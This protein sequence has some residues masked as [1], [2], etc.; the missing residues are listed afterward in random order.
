MSWA[1][2][3]V[4]EHLTYAAQD[5]AYTARVFQWLKRETAGD[6]RIAKLYEVHL[7][8]A[9]ICAE[10]HTRGVY[11]HRDNWE[12][13]RALC[14]QAVA[15]KRETLLSL[16]N[17]PEF[18]ATSQ[19]MQALMYERHKKPGRRCFG[20]PDP[21]DKRMYTDETQS[22]I[23]VDRKCL[24]LLQATTSDLPPDLLAIIAAW[25]KYQ[26]ELK[27]L[28][29]LNSALIQQAVG[30]DGRLRAGWNSC[31][32]DTM[33]FSCS[34]PN[35][36]QMEQLLRHLI[37]PAPDHVIV[38]AD[39][40]QLEI[41]VMEVVAADHVLGDAI[42]SGDIYSA[43]ACDY[44]GRD[45]ATFNPSGNK[46]DKASRQAA[47]IIRLARQYGAGKQTVFMQAL[48]QDPRFTFAAA[49][50]LTA[51]F[52]KRYY[53]TVKYWQEE[54]AR[55][56]QDGYSEGR[57]LHGRRTYARPPELSETVNY[58]IQRTAAEMMNQEIITLDRRL[59]AETKTAHIIIQLHDA[60]DVE[61]REHEEEKVCKIMTDV[62]HRDWTFCGMT[63]EFPIEM[64]VTRASEG[65][66]WA[67]V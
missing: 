15:E 16:V 47:K 12:F 6:E 45:P 4:E 51:K 35:L 39:K 30:P 22:S 33:R 63:R 56:K 28:G 41:R 2:S 55:V 44:F 65:G 46:A 43:E 48:M 64:K 31:G 10:M 27:R 3:K 11:F 62:M 29:Y 38:H 9:R 36:M 7:E 67:D 66:T 24:I 40:R 20:L 32:T 13:M 50:A 58:P 8:L 34:A 37:A 14:S 26:K 61:C 60:V 54:M 19:S 25:A 21:A 42:K 17:D 52:D 18:T 49:N 5:A 57:L 1:S 53:R 59:K 23:S